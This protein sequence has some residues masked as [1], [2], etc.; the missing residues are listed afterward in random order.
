MLQY[1]N[2]KFKLQIQDHYMK[3]EPTTAG[4]LPE[5]CGCVY[6]LCFRVHTD[7]GDD[8]LVNLTGGDSNCGIH[9]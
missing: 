4:Y 3:L 2:N 1:Y 8:W 7:N 5:A 6:T 9:V